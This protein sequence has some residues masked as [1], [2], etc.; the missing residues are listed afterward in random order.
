MT[1]RN[2]MTLRRWLAATVLAALPGLA[3]ASDGTL[4]VK[5]ENDGLASSDD[6]HFT[7]GVELNWTFRPDAEHWSQRVAARLPDTLIGQ[8][9][10]VAYRLIHQIYTPDDIEQRGLIEE[11]RPYAGLVFGGVSFYEDVARGDWRQATDLHLDVGMVGR[12]SQAERIQREAHRFS[13]SDRPRGWDNQLADEPIVNATLRRQ[14]WHESPL[15]GKTLAHGPS[16][17]LALGNLYTY[18]S[19]G[20]GVRFGDD[21]AGIPTV[22]PN[23]GGRQAFTRRS[24]LRWYLFAS[25]EG[26]YMAHNL[27]LDG[28]TVKSSHSVER[29]EWVGDL[30]GGAAL[31]WDAWQLSYT[32]VRRSHE[33]EGQTSHDVFGAVTLSRDF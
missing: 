16:A 9:D 29:R 19:G 10:A 22:T 13:R 28:N 17:G 15:A 33:F 1:Y 18:A 27:T 25:I 4:T 31:A 21:A 2:V 30:V 24:G 26:Y 23:P 8:A 7:S 32:A 5:V 11:D 14:W 20:Y 6:G 12:S 3:V